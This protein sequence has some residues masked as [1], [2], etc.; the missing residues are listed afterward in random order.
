MMALFLGRDVPS[1]T[2]GTN[3]MFY[4]CFKSKMATTTVQ[5]IT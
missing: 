3:F 2:P 4:L 1:M 5:C